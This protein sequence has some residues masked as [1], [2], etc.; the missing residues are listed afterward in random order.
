MKFYSNF[1]L[2]ENIKQSLIYLIEL[3]AQ[4]DFID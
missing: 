3:Q 4:I 1:F 2:T